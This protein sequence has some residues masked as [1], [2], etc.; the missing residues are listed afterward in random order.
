VQV[1][2]LIGNRTGLL[3]TCGCTGNL[4]GRSIQL[5]T[6]NTC[7]ALV[8]CAGTSPKSCQLGSMAKVWRVTG[9]ITCS[10]ISE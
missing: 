7:A 2:A 4:I 3:S 8:V 6:V 10:T 5:V 1:L 9:S